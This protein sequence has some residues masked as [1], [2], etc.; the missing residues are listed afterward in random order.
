MKKYQEWFQKKNM[1]IAAHETCYLK[2]HFYI[3]NGPYDLANFII[4]ISILG[5]LQLRLLDHAYSQ[6]SMQS[7]FISNVLL[8]TT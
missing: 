3:E 8:V 6:K 5:K 1:H 7:T 2:N 4:Q